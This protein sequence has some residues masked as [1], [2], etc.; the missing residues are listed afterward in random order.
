MRGGEGR[1]APVLAARELVVV[2]IIIIALV[3]ED[4]HG[5]RL[6][7]VEQR[8]GALPAALLLEQPQLLLQ[9]P[10]ELVRDV[11]VLLSKLTTYNKSYHILADRGPPSLRPTFFK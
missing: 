6:R 7:L 8:H 1:G 4:G 2:I 10:L 11:L 5:A 9:L 3:E